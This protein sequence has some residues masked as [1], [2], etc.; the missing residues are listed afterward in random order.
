MNMEEYKF[1]RHVRMPDKYKDFPEAAE[2][3]SLINGVIDIINN[4]HYS[5]QA[6]LNA[7]ANLHATVGTQAI[8]DGR[9]DMDDF[10]MGFYQIVSNTYRYQFEAKDKMDIE[11]AI[12]QLKACANLK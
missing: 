10:L 1:G 5:A 9:L 3:L 7:L 6:V 11:N 4:G 2:I 12:N 8:I